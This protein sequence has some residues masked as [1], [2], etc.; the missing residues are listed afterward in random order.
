MRFDN[1]PLDTQTCK[2]QVRIKSILP[3]FVIDTQFVSRSAPT[4]MTWPRWCSPRQ[5]RSRDTSRRRTPWCWTMRW[6]HKYRYLK[7]NM[8]YQ[9]FYI[10]FSIVIIGIGISIIECWMFQVN[11]MELSADDQVLGY[12]ELGNFSVA[13]FEM[14]L[15]RWGHGILSFYSA[16][17]STHLCPQ[18]F[19]HKPSLSP[20]KS[21]ILNVR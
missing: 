14:V 16:I 20:W 10:R 11:V 6:C 7:I 3:E 9:V 17:L 21:K 8:I 18:E 13:G 19:I 5:T 12:G 15:N 1:F 2:F 4:P